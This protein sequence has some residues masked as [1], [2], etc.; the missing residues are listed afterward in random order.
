LL[1]VAR[2]IAVRAKNSREPLQKNVIRQ[3]AA[4]ANNQA[5]IQV[6]RLGGKHAHT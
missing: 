6:F 2:E 1:P 3:I 4:A 5:S